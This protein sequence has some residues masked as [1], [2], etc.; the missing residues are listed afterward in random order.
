MGPVALFWSYWCALTVLA[1]LSLFAL[2]LLFSAL[3]RPPRDCPSLYGSLWAF[4]LSAGFSAT[5]LNAV[6][7]ILRF[8]SATPPHSL[9]MTAALTGLPLIGFLVMAFV[10]TALGLDSLAL[11]GERVLYFDEVL[12]RDDASAQVER[13]RLPR[14]WLLKRLTETY[15]RRSRQDYLRFEAKMQGLRARFRH[16][17]RHSVN[18]E[19]ILR[20]TQ[21]MPRLTRPLSLALPST[22]PRSSD[23]PTPR[24]EAPPDSEHFLQSGRRPTN[25]GGA[26]RPKESADDPRGGRPFSIGGS[27]LICCAAL[28]DGVLLPC[29]HGGLCHSC[30]CQ[31]L[32][33]GCHLCREQVSQVLRLDIASAS[34]NYIKVVEVSYQ[35]GQSPRSL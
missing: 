5:S 6:L 24:T 18:L 10:L 15:F 28:P 12:V 31:L 14:P 17:T 21:H 34:F 3:C 27:C 19:S 9:E 25:R 20:G 35:A 2:L 30:G 1:M 33:E 22:T 16:P 4:L 8:A 11:W 7:Q 29:G 23:G 32:G 26:G 13:R